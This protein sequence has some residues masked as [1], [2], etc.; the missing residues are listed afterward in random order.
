MKQWI[1]EVA[2]GKKRARD[3]TFD[4]ASQAAQS[5]IDGEATDIQVAAFLIAQRLKNESPDELA[6]FVTQFRQAASLIP[7]SPDKRQQLIDFSGPYDGRKTFAATIPSALLMAAE[8]IPVFLHSS[9]T[10]PPKYGSSLKSILD[11]LGVTPDLDA[12]S[13]GQSIDKHCIGF[14]HTE[15][16]CQPLANVRHI[17]EEIG[18]RSFINMAEKLLNLSNAPSV[19][20]GI[21]HKTVLDTNVD[22]LRRLN[23]QKAFIV[24]GAEGSEDLPIHRKSFIYEITEDTVISRDLDPA[25]YHLS[26]RKDPDKEV[27]TLQEQAEL[28]EAIVAGETSDNLTYYRN[29]VIFN[30]A[31]RYYLFGKVRSLA[32]GIDLTMSQLEDGSGRDQLQKW[33]SFMK[34][35]KK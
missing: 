11:E 23:F 20:L 31:A 8:R 13:I 33:Q 35:V 12:D 27:L 5:I 14:A 21:F 9:D 15:Q 17:R 4:E 19:M 10:L 29:Q 32:E 18:V 24:Q 1:K 2:K 34:V 25:D 22:N 3:L 6:A 16:L 28:I 30:T 7:I 26:C